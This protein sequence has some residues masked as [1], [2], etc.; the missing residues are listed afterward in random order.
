MPS[1]QLRQTEKRRDRQPQPSQ[2]GL[3]PLNIS[4][5]KLLPMI[6]DLSNLRWPKSIKIDP[7]KRDQSRKC[8]YHKDHGH[9]T[10]QCMSL[11]YLVERL[12]KVG[13]LKQYI[14]SDKRRTETTWDPDVQVPMASTAPKAVISY[15]HKGPI[16]EKYNS[17]SKRQR[18][19]KA[20]PLGNRSALSNTTCQEVHARWTT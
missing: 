7:M 11:H 19:L 14:L 15:I 5:D 18:L 9:T 6:L 10:K 8:V 16:D 2:A 17:K 1:N 3:T 4:Y 13:H 12:I 20:T